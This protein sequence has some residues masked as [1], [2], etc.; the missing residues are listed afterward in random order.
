MSV[1]MCVIE[2]V[3]LLAC[4]TQRELETEAAEQ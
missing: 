4:G 3:A 1:R 2:R